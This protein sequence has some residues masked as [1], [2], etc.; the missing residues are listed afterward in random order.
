HWNYYRC[1]AK[2]EGIEAAR[3]GLQMWIHEAIPIAGIDV[4]NTIL[5]PAKDLLGEES[6]ILAAKEWLQ[7][8]SPHDPAHKMTK[9]WMERINQGEL[10]KISWRELP[11][12][13]VQNHQPLL[14]PLNNGDLM[15]AGGIDS[16]GRPSPKSALWSNK[17]KSWTPLPPLP[18]GLKNHSGIAINKGSIIVLGGTAATENGESTYSKR[19]FQWSYSTGSWKEIASLQIGRE[20]CG[21]SLGKSGQIIV[22][23]GENPL[24]TQTSVEYWDR[25]SNNWMLGVSIG[26]S[27][28]EI[29]LQRVQDQIIIAGASVSSSGF[30]AILFDLNTQKFSQPKALQGIGLDGAHPIS[31]GEI[32]IWTKKSGEINIGIWSPSHETIHWTC[33]EIELP[34]RGDLAC[35]YPYEDNNF[36]LLFSQNDENIGSYIIDPT[37][38]T[39]TPLRAPNKDLPPSDYRA[40]PFP[41]GLFVITPQSSWLLSY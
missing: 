36:T 29:Q 15:V 10:R 28:Q 8:S 14:I 17:S 6:A 34:H 9:R 18:V 5:D 30:G 12:C 11:A 2:M 35:V 24:Q 3:D 27:L 22:I 38:G 37:S 13:P 1:I 7:I 21:V 4:I 40:C 41:Y 31:S 16:S 33:K 23:G 26:L 25:R 32:V 39:L 19:V 20:F